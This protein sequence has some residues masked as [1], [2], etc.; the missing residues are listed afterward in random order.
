MH[1]RTGSSTLP[2]AAQNK[3]KTMAIQ[4]TYRR[5]LDARDIAIYTE[6]QALTS[7]PNN[8]REEIRAMLMRK[9]HLHSR[10]AIHEAIKR[11]EKK[12]NENHTAQ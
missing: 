7:D 9:H 4:T 8:S 1:R 10:S 2:T 6:W 11:G 12:I 5:K 3:K